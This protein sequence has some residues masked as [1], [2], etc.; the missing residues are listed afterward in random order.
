MFVRR[1]TYDKVVAELES[2]KAEL[3]ACT[4]RY[5]DLCTRHTSL[6]YEILSYKAYVDF[7]RQE[8]DNA[9]PPLDD[10]MIKRMISLCHPDKHDGRKVAQEVT[11]Y[12][13]NLRRRGK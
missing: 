2:T 3:E 9:T 13:N 1:S 7:C 12:L 6:K 4:K 5:Y 8:L 10:D 11:S